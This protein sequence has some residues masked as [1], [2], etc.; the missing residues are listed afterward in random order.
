MQRTLTPLTP[1]LVCLASALF[2]FYAYFQMA[3]FNTLSSEFLQAFS[4]SPAGLGRLQAG[5]FM[6]DAIIL[7]PAGIL[8]DRYS[9][10]TLCL[11]VMAATVVASMGLAGTHSVKMAM[12]CHAIG[13]IGN[14]FSFLGSMQLASRWLPSKHLALG[15]GGI[16]TLA[17][18]G[19]V[20]AQ[21][22]LAWV[23]TTV[24]WRGALW[25]NVV[26]GFIILSFMWRYLL[27]PKVITPKKQPWAEVFKQLW[28]V[29]LV[30][31]NW[32]CSIFT[33]L[34]NL[35]IV[36]L[37]TLWGVLFLTQ[38]YGVS[39]TEAASI[40]SFIFFG[41]I[42]GSPIVGWISDRIQS[43]KTLMV[44][45]TLLGILILLSL[46]TTHHWGVPE[47]GMAFFMLGFLMS[48]QVMS[49]PMLAEINSV[50]TTGTAMSLLAIL[51]NLTC[52]AIQPFFGW[53]TSLHGT[54]H[55]P[56]YQAA[57]WVLP[58]ACLIALGVIL[59]VRE[60]REL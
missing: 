53:M 43:R 4:L 41:M 54:E 19:G 10:R 3:M 7:L 51:L 39:F 58:V 50:D 56:N 38:A 44:V 6:A 34:L 49:Y 24:G 29:C 20:A 36:V 60:K 2:F 31:Q 11:I 59:C 48:A 17:M 55:A 25:F 45:G 22:P 23:V 14:A 35:P 12:L 16:V 57:V 13:G 1:W 28:K 21:A 30:P 18:L 27:D 5:Y 42:I 40:T 15:M 47:L 32:S 33:S 46:M 37:G 52:A 9:T 8:L 26:L